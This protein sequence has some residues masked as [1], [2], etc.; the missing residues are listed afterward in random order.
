MSQNG[1]K[2]PTTIE[3]QCDFLVNYALGLGCEQAGVGI[4]CDESDMEGL[5]DILAMCNTGNTPTSAFPA[6]SI[7]YDDDDSVDDDMSAVVA[8]GAGV[9]SSLWLLESH[10]NSSHFAFSVCHKRI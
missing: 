9:R 5:N 10:N 8:A 2:A 1:D 7:D 3:E 4:D 6:D